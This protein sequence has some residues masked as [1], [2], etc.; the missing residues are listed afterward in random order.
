MHSHLK[1][2]CQCVVSVNTF[3]SGK[4]H[5]ANCATLEIL[6]QQQVILIDIYMWE[7]KISVTEVFHTKLAFG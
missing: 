1:L 5:E 3:G 4:K 6:R 7:Y 2:F